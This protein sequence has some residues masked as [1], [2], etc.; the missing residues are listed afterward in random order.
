MRY[1]ILIGL[2]TLLLLTSCEIREETLECYK[3]NS[4]KIIELTQDCTI[5]DYQKR[6]PNARRWCITDAQRMVCGE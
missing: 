4:E 2:L 5:N 1:I 3:D 6:Q